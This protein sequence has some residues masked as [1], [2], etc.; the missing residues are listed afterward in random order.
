MTKNDGDMYSGHIHYSPTAWYSVGYRGEH[1]RADNYYLHAL[2]MNNLLKRWN[3]PASQANL[4]LKSGVGFAYSDKG[5]F[6]DEYEPLL[7]TGLS[8]DWEDRRYFVGHEF[9]LLYADEIEK[10]FEQH[11]RLGFAPYIG[12]YGDLH[13]WVMLKLSHHPESEDSFTLTPL[14]RFFKGVHL[15]E[16]GVSESGD[17]M[18]NGIIRF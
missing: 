13:T 5:A 11:A 3:G 10:S 6:D 18:M 9:R 2:A 1:W 17:F 4:Y 8:A 12:E 7:Y 16:V 14:L 15:L